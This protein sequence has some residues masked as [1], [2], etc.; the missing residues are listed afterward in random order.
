MHTGQSV[1]SSESH[2]G[3]ANVKSNTHRDAET[4]IL[5]SETKMGKFSDLI[6]KHIYVTDR[7]K[8]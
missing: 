1:F 8:N 3:V 4:G 5:K 7:W 2:L 6:E